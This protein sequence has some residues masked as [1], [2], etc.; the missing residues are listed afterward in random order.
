MNSGGWLGAIACHYPHCQQDAQA[1]PPPWVQAS[2]TIIATLSNPCRH[3]DAPTRKRP[4]ASASKSRPQRSPSSSQS[5]NSTPTCPPQL[6]ER[7]RA[8]RKPS[9]HTTAPGVPTNRIIHTCT[10]INIQWKRSDTGHSTFA[11]KPSTSVHGKPPPAENRTGAG[12][13]SS[14]CRVCR[15]THALPKGRASFIHSSYAQWTDN[16]AGRKGRCAHGLL[17][18]SGVALAHR[19]HR[20]RRVSGHLQ[21]RVPQRGVCLLS[22]WCSEEDAPCSLLRYTAGRSVQL[23]R[24]PMKRVC[25]RHAARTCTYTYT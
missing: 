6:V 17:V 11:G 20:P 25:S 2:V 24:C 10:K 14:G 22:A 3:T 15:R 1:T 16:A 21:D 23:C 12:D 8:Q 4:S 7:R 5:S 9:V 13:G 18:V 19:N